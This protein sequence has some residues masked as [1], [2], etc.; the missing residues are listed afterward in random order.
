MKKPKRRRARGLGSIRKIAEGKWRIGYDAPRSNDWGPRRQRYETVFG[1]KEQAEGVL[2]TRLA[3]V[4]S[5]GLPDEDRLTFNALADRY[6]KAKSVSREGT[7]VALYRRILAQHVRPAIGHLRLRNIR[8]DHI[9][10]L[11][12]DAKNRG[13]TPSKNAPLSPVT[14]RNLL[15]MV[16]AVFAWAV[17]QGL[18][19]RNVANLVEPPAVPHAERARI[20]LEQVRALLAAST[21]TELAAII[22]F[23]IGTGLRRSELCALRWG[24]V[25]LQLGT[26]HVQRAAANLGGGVIIK[27]PKTKRSN[28][29]D[30]LPAFVVAVLRRHRA[31]Q[32]QRHESFGARAPGDGDV[33]FDRLD[34]RA[35]DPNELSRHFMKLVRAHHLPP[36]RFHDLRHAYASL[37][38][39]SGTSLKVVSESLGHSAVAVTDA[40]YVHLQDAARREKAERLDTYLEDVVGGLTAFVTEP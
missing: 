24:D 1:V 25:D 28:R 34:G 22:P 13:R 35:W 27:A 16:R 2:R 29:I 26:I 10:G 32:A 38:F 18:L 31:A 39:A 20:G 23:A 12:L 40:I 14:Q 5:G 11:V 37:A 21:G 9:A 4:R 19:L 8:A 36:Q 33:I 30:A 7:T 17:R 15:T 6:L 3:E